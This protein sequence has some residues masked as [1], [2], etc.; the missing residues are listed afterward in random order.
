ML[1][2]F[3][4]A[5]RTPS[6]SISPMEEADLERIELAKEIAA[7]Q[8]A[9]DI[10]AVQRDIDKMI[11]EFEGLQFSPR[12]GNEGQRTPC[13]IKGPPRWWLG[14][15]TEAQQERL[16][17][18]TVVRPAQGCQTFQ[19]FLQTKAKDRKRRNRQRKRQR[20]ARER[21][22]SQGLPTF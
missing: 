19:E 8:E 5:S 10:A 1:P 15:L 7:R 22:A 17:P 3:P 4:T 16:Y 11:R 12:S 21:L 20:D 14:P 9:R 6:V 18:G 2:D 13:K